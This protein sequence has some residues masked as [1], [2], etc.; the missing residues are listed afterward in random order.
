MVNTV[1]QR[2]T[3]PPRHSFFLLGVRGV[4]KS[5]WARKYF[6]KATYIDMLD[7]GRYQDYLA[8][9]ALFAAEL[10][11]VRAG[12]WVVVDEIQRL[13]NLLNEVHRYIEGRRLK[14]A[15]LGSSVRKLKTA[16][17]NLLAGWALRR[18]MH[19]FTAFELGKDF[20]LNQVF[21]FGTIPLAWVADEK[22][23][24]LESYVQLYLREEIRA[25]ALVRNLPGCRGG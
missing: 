22:K 12:A 6:A 13:P 23:A 24:I 4:G 7:E 3:A 15:L 2:L 1:Y 8:D 5:T 25:E 18:V 16:G 17:V 11:A 9:P 10:E 20:D 21:R 14:F 19:P